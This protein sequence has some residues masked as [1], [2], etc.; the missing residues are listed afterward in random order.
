MRKFFWFF[1]QEDFFAEISHGGSA[2]TVLD[3]EVNQEAFT[4]CGLQI[5]KS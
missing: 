5:S 4:M 3:F 2:A 1:K